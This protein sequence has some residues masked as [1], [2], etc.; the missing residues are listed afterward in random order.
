MFFKDGICLKTES[1]EWNTSV[2]AYNVRNADISKTGLLTTKIAI[3]HG[4]DLI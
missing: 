4:Y 1:A 3:N 2:N